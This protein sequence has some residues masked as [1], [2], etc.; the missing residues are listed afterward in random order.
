MQ[1]R[2][3]NEAKE[4]G[5]E[6]WREQ[7]KSKEVILHGLKERSQVLGCTFIPSH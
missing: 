5:M 3:Y 4:R 2:V 6:G 7:Q 1:R